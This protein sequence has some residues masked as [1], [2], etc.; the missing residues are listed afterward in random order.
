MSRIQAFVR[1]HF[2]PIILL[3]LAAGFVIT[4]LELYSYQHWRGTQLIG[5]ASTIAGLV[6]VLVGIVVKRGLRITVAVLL[7]ALSVAGLIGTW[8]HYESTHG[9]GDEAA[10]P[11]LAQAAQGVTN[12][13]IAYQL[14]NNT[15]ATVAQEGGEQ[16]EGGEGAAPQAAPRTGQSFEGRGRKIPAP[17]LA[18]LAISGLALMG[19]VV[20][21]AKKDEPAQ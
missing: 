15:A 2:N 13:P 21:L 20:L 9:E 1:R 3:L 18:P 14:G 19:A 8:E 11:A 5:F 6:L 17:L 10:R 16:G 7:L 4:L 12:Q